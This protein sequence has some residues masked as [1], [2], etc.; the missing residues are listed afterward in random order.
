MVSRQTVKQAEENYRVT[1]EKYKQG[2]TLNSEL[3]DAEV[4]LAQAR[5][6]YVQ[7]Q[8]DYELS[9]AKLDRAIGIK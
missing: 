6:D 1:D 3:L 9:L 5:T 2:L 7:A 8:V 4:A